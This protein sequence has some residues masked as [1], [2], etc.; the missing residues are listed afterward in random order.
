MI[1]SLR[2]LA[3]N[4]SPALWGQMSCSFSWRWQGEGVKGKRIKTAF[5][6]LSLGREFPP[7]KSQASAQFLDPLVQGRDS[8]ASHPPPQPDGGSLFRSSRARNVFIATRVILR[9]GLAGKP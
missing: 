3:I 2:S 9:A 4:D 8:L 6:P 7:E 1:A 5:A